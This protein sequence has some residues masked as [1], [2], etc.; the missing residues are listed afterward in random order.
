MNNRV[1]YTHSRPDGSI[2]YVGKG[3]GKRPFNL[4][5]NKWHD[6]IVA[7]YGAENIKV[8]I[9]DSGLDDAAAKELEVF[10]ISELILSGVRLTNMTEGGEGIKGLV[11]SKESREKMSLS[12]KARIRTP[13]ELSRMSSIAK[14]HDKTNP[15]YREKCRQSALKRGKR[16]AEERRNIS[17]AQRKRKR[18]IKSGDSFA[19][20]PRAETLKLAKSVMALFEKNLSAVEIGEIVG[21]SAQYVNKIRRRV[22]FG[23]IKIT[24]EE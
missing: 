19:K 2:F 9:V 17:I 1:V 21:H 5:R 3:V 16:S 12:Q 23:M 8:D 14:M 18:K 4:H 22:E 10:L 6:A 7:K 20:H 13:E 24:N 15:E 11:H